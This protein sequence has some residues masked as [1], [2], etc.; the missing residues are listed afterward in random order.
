MDDFCLIIAIIILA[1][2]SCVAGV[3]SGIGSVENYFEKQ[4]LI[5]NQVVI[6]GNKYQCTLIKE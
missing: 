4:C 6:S 2:S 3:A 5:Q 1:V